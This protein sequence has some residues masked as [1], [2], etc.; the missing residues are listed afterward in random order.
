M[1]I[2][3]F[4]GYSMFFCYLYAYVYIERTISCIF[5]NL[6]CIVKKLFYASFV[7]IPQCTEFA[8]YLQLISS[9]YNMWTW[10]HWCFAD[11][12]IKIIIILWWLNEAFV[13]CLRNRC[14]WTVNNI[15]LKTIL[16]K[17]TRFCGCT[18]STD[19]IY[20]SFTYK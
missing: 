10:A 3:L 4:V 2:W 5:I 1:I 7:L 11:Y 18:H 17:R 16:F 6:I 14:R 9:N 13:F 8:N 15:Q 12:T 19:L 20:F